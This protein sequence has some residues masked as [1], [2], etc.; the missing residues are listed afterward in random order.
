[1][2]CCANP[3]GHSEGK[4][5][6]GVRGKTAYVLNVSDPEGDDGTSFPVRGG[7]YHYNA[8][9]SGSLEEVWT[10]DCVK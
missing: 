6:R 2:T 7:V 10:E 5:F 8:G 9:V 1:M 4:Q 3:D